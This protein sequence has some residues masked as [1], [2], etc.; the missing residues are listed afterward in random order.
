MPHAETS[1]TMEDQAEATFVGEEIATVGVDWQSG[2]DLEQ[3]WN[4]MMQ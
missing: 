4:D 3:A 1:L 2:A